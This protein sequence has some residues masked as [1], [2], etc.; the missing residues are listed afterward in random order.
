M[1]WSVSSLK[2]REGAKLSSGNESLQCPG[3]KL[4]KDQLWEK[5]NNV[6]YIIHG[7]GLTKWTHPVTR[8]WREK[9]EEDKVTLLPWTTRWIALT[10]LRLQEAE[11]ILK[12]RCSVSFGLCRAWRTCMWICS[13]RFIQQNCC[14]IKMVRSAIRAEWPALRSR[15]N[16]DDCNQWGWNH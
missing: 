2:G 16:G 7:S 3:E 4:Y 1:K 15:W 6:Q 8:C 14:S 13:V 10:L 9:V 12:E 5:R 11:Q